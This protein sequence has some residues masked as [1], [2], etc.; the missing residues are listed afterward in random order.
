MPTGKVRFY[1]GDKGFG[2]IT[3]DE[4]GDVFL[5]AK[6]LP[7]GVTSLKGGTRL[8]YSIAEGRKGAQAMSVRV[9]DPAPSVV[10]NRRERDRKPTEDMVVIVEDLMQVLDHVSTS[11]RKGHYPERPLATK[12]SALLRAVATDLEA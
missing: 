2:F 1:D 11:L 8:E 10:A 4:G 7:E 12:V 3:D 6:A 9:L 5:G